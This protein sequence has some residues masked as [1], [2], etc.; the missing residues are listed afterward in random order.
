MKTSNYLTSI[1]NLSI[2]VSIVRPQPATATRSCGTSPPLTVSL[3]EGVSSRDSSQRTTNTD[4]ALFPRTASS[5]NL[6][7][8]PVT[9]HTGKGVA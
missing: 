3:S 1:L 7:V 2:S 9:Y 4:V 8:F 5:L 6:H